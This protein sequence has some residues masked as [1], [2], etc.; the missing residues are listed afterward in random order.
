MGNVTIMGIALDTLDFHVVGKS[1]PVINA[2][3][4]KRIITFQ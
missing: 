1:I 2:M 3:I 4:Y